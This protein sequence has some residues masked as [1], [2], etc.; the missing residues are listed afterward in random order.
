MF[1]QEGRSKEYQSRGPQGQRGWEQ[2]PEDIHSPIQSEGQRMLLPEQDEPTLGT[3]LPC[4]SVAQGTEAEFVQPRLQEAS[5]A[6]LPQQVLRIH[7][8]KGSCRTISGPAPDI[9]LETGAHLGH[10]GAQLCCSSCSELRLPPHR[11]ARARSLRTGRATHWF[12]AGPGELS[13]A[14]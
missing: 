4:S 5:C 12:S 6:L 11:L 10:P 2:L 8:M 9:S 7:V 1:S 3:L 14:G 13:C